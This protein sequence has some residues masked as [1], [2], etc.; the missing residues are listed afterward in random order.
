[1]GTAAVAAL[2]EGR[3]LRNA[4]AQFATG[5]AIVTA[6]DDR[7]RRAGVTINSFASVSLA[8]PLV[9]WSL[10]A[11]AAS[12]PV[13]EAADCHAINVL[14]EGQGTLAQRFAAREADRLAG[15]PLREGAFGALL[16]DGALA[17]FVCRV[18][19]RRA[20]GD[21]LLFVCEVLDHVYERGA[22][23]VFHGSRYRSLGAFIDVRARALSAVSAK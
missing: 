16:V 6:R 17:H 8:P 1:M 19:E 14:A 5:V 18:Q 10:G 12:R 15:V 4:L 2:G 13:F 11:T 23:L 20:I 9:L 22:P 21:H 7:G 3:A